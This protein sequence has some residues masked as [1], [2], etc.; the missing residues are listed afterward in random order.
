MKKAS[1]IDRSQRVHNV[2]EALAFMGVAVLEYATTTE[3]SQFS[4]AASVIHPC[5]MEIDGR[6]NA[7]KVD[8]PLS[9]AKRSARNLVELK[10][11]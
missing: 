11:I 3:R 2:P 1:L 10:V 9:R 7:I 5:H 4:V 6:C 8:Q